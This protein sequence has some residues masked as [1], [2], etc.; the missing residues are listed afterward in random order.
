MSLAGRSLDE[1]LQFNTT[2]FHPAHAAF[3]EAVDALFAYNDNS[4]KV[5]GAASQKSL[6]QAL[7]VI[8]ATAFAGLVI[9]I[10]FAMVIT[11]GLGKAL[12]HVAHV[13]DD[14]SDQVAAAATEVAAGSQ[15]LAQGV[16]EQAASLEETSSSLEEMS[17]LTSR[18]ADN[19][20]NAKGF[21]N[22]TRQAAETGAAEMEKMTSAMNAI[23]NS[24]DNIAKIIK[25]IDEIAFHT[26]ILALNAAVDAARAGEAGMGFAVV[27]DEVRNLAQRSA[28]AARE[29]A[30]KIEDSI[31]KSEHG[32]QISIN[33]S[34]SLQE[35]V[36]KARQVDDLLGE[37]A[38]ASKEQSQG[39][40]QVNTAVVQMD[41][42]TQSSA[43]GAEESASAAEELNAQAKSL[44]DSVC[45][46][47]A[48]VEGRSSRSLGSPASAPLHA[49][50]NTIK[51]HQNGNTH[52][53][54]TIVKPRKVFLAA[55][56]N[57][58]KEDFKSSLE[59]VAFTGQ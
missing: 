13:L 24:S 30:D 18:N 47:L 25:T 36:T 27:A 2:T 10:V 45:L 19:A 58:I 50:R 14:G 54:Q 38:N 34:S 16:S 48:L 17:S 55:A 5:N 53:A 22:L 46:L 12:R 57:P 39:I 51:S 37:I 21:S 44:K 56:E 6:S 11:I 4:G 49:P 59:T 1:A 29:T 20:Q 42:V 33:V 23:K 8:Y 26:N 3:S 9:G 41:K 52:S 40:D 28:Q 32:V 7:A 43:A 31:K 35:I 15:S